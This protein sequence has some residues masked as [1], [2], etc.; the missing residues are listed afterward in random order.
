MLLTIKNAGRILDLYS[1]QSPERGP[2]E[3]AEELGIGKSKAHA[4][5]AS[6]AEI[7]LLRRTHEGRY[8]AGWRALALERIARETTPFRTIAYEVAGRLARHSGEVVHVAALDCGRVVYVDR[9]LGSNAIDIPLSKV[10]STLPAHCTGVGKVLLAHVEAGELDAI[11]DRHGLPSFTVNTITDRDALYAELHRVRRDGIAVD[12][13]EVADGLACVA[14]P[15]L[16]VEGRVCA[17]ISIAAPATRFA[18]AGYAYRRAVV[19]AARVVSEKVRE[20]LFQIGE[21]PLTRP[22]VATPRAPAR[23]RRSSLPAPPRR[24]ADQAP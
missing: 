10:G 17:A 24:G 20:P 19:R 1:P 12:R 11:L 2:T 8:R 3:V 23:R 18:S 16:D 15:I 21:R 5:M 13:G 9:L 4:L 7:G 6:M 14:A 22:P